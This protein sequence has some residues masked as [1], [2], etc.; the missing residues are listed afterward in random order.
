MTVREREKTGP[1]KRKNWTALSEEL[2]VGGN[3]NMS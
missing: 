1:L 3:M 2:S